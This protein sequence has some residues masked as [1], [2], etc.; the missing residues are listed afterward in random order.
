MLH[1]NRRSTDVDPGNRREW[2]PNVRSCFTPDLIEEP[3]RELQEDLESGIM[4]EIK[5][6]M[7]DPV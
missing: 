3:D 4:S 2:C 1:T 7:F 6:R 5:K